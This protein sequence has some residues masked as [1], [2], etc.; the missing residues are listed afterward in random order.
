MLYDPKWEQKTKA[1]PF[2]LETFVAWLETRDPAESY[3]YCNPSD[4]LLCRYF[5]AHGFERPRVALNYVSGTEFPNELKLL[6]H[7]NGRQHGWTVGA[8]LNRA[9]A[10]AR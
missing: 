9:R 10:I 1:D 4:C 7:G 5:S 8:A 3:D 2:K 6:S